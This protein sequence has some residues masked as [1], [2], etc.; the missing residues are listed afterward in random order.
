MTRDMRVYFAHS[1]VSRQNETRLA[2]SNGSRERRSLGKANRKIY[3]YEY[4]FL[5]FACSWTKFSHNKENMTLQSPQKKN[6][7]NKA[8]F[9][10]SPLTFSLFRLDLLLNVL[11]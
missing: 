10:S 8:E 6:E 3:G 9:I 2:M 5:D 7:H 1:F 11:N 4:D